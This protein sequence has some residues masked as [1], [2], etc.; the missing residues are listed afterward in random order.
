VDPAQRN[1]LVDCG[2]DELACVVVYCS[3]CSTFGLSN[4]NVFAVDSV[5]CKVGASV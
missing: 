5:L 4:I 2:S 3:V 1:L